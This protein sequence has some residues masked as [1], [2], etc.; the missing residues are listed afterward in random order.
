MVSSTI[1]NTTAGL[2]EQVAQQWP[3]MGA[4]RCHLS[5]G[6]SGGLDSVVLLHILV[7][8]RNRLSI[9]LSAIHVHHGLS[10]H[11]DTWLNFCQQLCQQWQ[12]PLHAEKVSVEAKTQGIEAAA[13]TARYQ[14]YARSQA[15]VIALAHHADDQVETFFLAA[16]RGGGLRALAAMPVQ[17]PLNDQTVLWRPLLPFSRQILQ[18]Y[19]DQFDLKHIED[20]S[21]ADGYFL[22]NWLR[23]YGLPPWRERQPALDQ[24]LQATVA[25]LQDELSLL[26]EVILADWQQIH[27]ATSRFQVSIWRQLSPARQRQQLHQFARQHQLG[28]PRSVSIQAFAEQLLL[29]QPAQWSLPQGKAIYYDDILWPCWSDRVRQWPWL[30]HMPAA[31][32]TLVANQEIR[33]I[34]HALGLADRLSEKYTVRCVKSQD[35]IRLQGGHKNVKKLLQSCKI[36]AFMRLIWPI[37]CDEHDCCIAVINIAVDTDLAIPDGWLPYMDDL[38]FKT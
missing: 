36:P 35:R 5:V 28:S 27:A 13:R 9:Q 16:L 31:I 20:D 3:A 4:G 17:R 15:E 21:N 10:R 11:A 38:P 22:R 1:S 37:V 33:W 7:Q 30:A 23:L 29:D 26:D 18:N 24:H 34:R 6:L 14:V 12:V 2:I 25:R 19:A 32:T 8:L